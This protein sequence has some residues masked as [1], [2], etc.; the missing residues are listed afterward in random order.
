MLYR[1][2]NI[3]LLVSHFALKRNFVTRKCW[4]GNRDYMVN[5]HPGIAMLGSQLTGLKFFHVI[6]MLIFSV[7]HGR[8]EIPTNR[9]SPAK[10]A[11]PPHV[12]GPLVFP[13]S[14]HYI[15]SSSICPSFLPPSQLIS[16]SI[17]S[18]PPSLP[19]LRPHFL[20]KTA[21]HICTCNYPFGLIS[22]PTKMI[23]NEI[24]NL[25][26]V[27]GSPFSHVLKIPFKKKKK[28]T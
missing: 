18:S 22:C 25:K 3:D 26:S 16:P 17:S 15:L 11:S 14:P 5:F 2:R 13:I 6:A 24:I 9:A 19:L 23:N 10:R 4:P 20:K 7:F 21:I 1:K 8:A 27:Q 28:N 12:I